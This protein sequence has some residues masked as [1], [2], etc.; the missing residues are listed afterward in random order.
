MR[1]LQ[2]LAKGIESLRA[3]SRAV[4]K[5]LQQAI[6]IA[7]SDAA[8]WYQ[9]GVAGIRHW[10][11]PAKPSKK[12]KRRSRSI[13]T[14]RERTQPWRGFRPPPARGTAP[15]RRCGKLFALT[16]TMRPPGIWPAGRWPRKGQFPEALY[17]FEKA[18][19]HRP[20][21]AP[22]LY[23]YALDAVQREPVRSRAGIRRSGLRADPNLAE[24]SR[25]AGRSSCEKAATARSGNGV[26]GSAPAASGF[27][28]AR[29]W[30]WPRS[31]RRRATC[32]KR[33]SNCA[34]RSKGSDPEVARL[35]AGA[36]QRL[37]ER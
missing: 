22:Y 28:S 6:Q 7:P 18:I 2:S 36:L 12:C 9:S 25:L 21:F 35:A 26:S 11:E 32:R 5:S 15:K 33:C 8:S 17:D 20:D 1:A 3:A 23:D 30:I 24:A 13:R 10:G 16:L 37:G 14:C 31:W 34:K 19:R 4:R 27:R 29:D